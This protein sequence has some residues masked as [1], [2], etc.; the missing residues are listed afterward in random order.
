[1]THRRDSLILVVNS[2]GWLGRETKTMTVRA[3]IP[4]ELEKRLD[5]EA[6]QNAPVT[7]AVYV[8]DILE[9]MFASHGRAPHFMTATKQEWLKP[10][11]ASTDSHDA[12]LPPLSEEAVS[13]ESIYGER[14]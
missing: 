11:H 5:E 4:P 1:M 9:R 2:N 14:G 12:T 7:T 13:C 6:V 10:F 8:R 3:Q